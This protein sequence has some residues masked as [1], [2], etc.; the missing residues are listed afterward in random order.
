MTKARIDSL[1]LMILGTVAFILFGAVLVNRIPRMD[2]RTAYYGGKCLL[3][4]GCD[5]YNEDDIDALYELKPE[6]TATSERIRSVVVRNI[7]L[8]TAFPFTA[9]LALLPFNLAQA[10]WSTLIAGSFILAAYLM[11]SLG[12]AQAPLI[13]GSMLAFCLADSGSV[14]FFSNPAG[15][16]VPLCIVAA[17]CFVTNRLVP[18]GILSL[19]VALAFK[20]HDAVFIWLYFLLAGGLYKRRALQTL[21]LF[22][23]FSAPAVLWIAQVSPD[24]L[25]EIAANLQV[26]SAKGGINDPSVGH[27]T[28]MLTNLQTITSF[29]WDNP[30]AYD[31]ASYLLCAP[32]LMIWAF[33]TWRSRPSQEGTWFGLASIAVLSMLP[34]YHRQYDAKLIMLSIPALAILWRQRGKRAW[35]GLFV[36]ASAFIL[37]GDLPWVTFLAIVNKLNIPSDASYGRFLTAVLDFP[38]P[39]SL[40]TMGAF[41][42][43]VYVRNTSGVPAEQQI[44][45]I[46]E[47]RT[48][49]T[50]A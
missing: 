34:V 44:Q 47:F 26:Y 20:P 14:I 19:A 5:P 13:A 45:E 32:F 38:V 28:E 39:L 8:P 4:R 7:Y 2:F 10:L 41:Y 48:E 30:R 3:H 31:L 22:V 29:F 18:W 24:F 12:A 17:W 37:N 23:A 36:T 21:A 16:V 40:L 43:W 15:F 9:P 46:K 11:W 1:Y 50:S 25:H 27:G 49:R 35:I 33:V 6:H 42:L